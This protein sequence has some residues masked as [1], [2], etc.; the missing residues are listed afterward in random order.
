MTI[1]TI[2]LA[3]YLVYIIH[4]SEKGRLIVKNENVAHEN[5]DM[6]RLDCKYRLTFVS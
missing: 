5:V 6:K 4:V 1:T 3:H 2:H